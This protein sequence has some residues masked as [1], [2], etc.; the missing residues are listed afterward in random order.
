MLD[1]LIQKYPTG[2]ALITDF[3]DS[4]PEIMSTTKAR[5]HINRLDDESESVRKIFRKRLSRWYL[6]IPSLCEYMEREEPL[7]D[8][9]A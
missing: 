6:H 5:K 7:I 3:G 8:S 1:Y 9:V 4:F 2:Y